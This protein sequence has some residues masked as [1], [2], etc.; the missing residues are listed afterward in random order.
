MIGVGLLMGLAFRNPGLTFVVVAVVGWL[1]VIC[2]YLYAEGKLDS[3]ARIRP[4]G[5]MLDLLIGS[6]VPALQ[7]SVPS[8]AS[9]Q[10]GVAVPK[11]KERTSEERQAIAD[12]AGRKLEQLLGIDAVKVEVNRLIKAGE[13]ARRRGASGFGVDALAT[14]VILAGARGTGKST[15]A[16]LL[17]P[18]LYGLQVIER[19]E[20]LKLRKAQLGGASGAALSQA[21]EEAAR[22]SFGGVLLIDGADWLVETSQAG[23]QAPASDLGH[24]LIGA[25]EKNP[26]KLIVVLCGSEDAMLKLRT[27]PDQAFWVGKFNVTYIKFPHLPEDDLV[28]VLDSALGSKNLKLDDGAR[29]TVK[30]ELKQLSR[31]H[32]ANFDNATAARR[33]ADQLVL[34]VSTTHDDG[35]ARRTVTAADVRAVTEQQ[36]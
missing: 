24:G 6:S 11:Q 25:T 7:S 34:Q 2:G 18:I 21:I 13:A 26:G 5:M 30:G 20:P 28:S 14:L 12:A 22:T 36:V 33:L 31:R 35:P 23:S 3:L 1:I 4:V 16:E 8:G 17:P 29:G 9:N 27:D 10:R 19:E 15:V 32:G